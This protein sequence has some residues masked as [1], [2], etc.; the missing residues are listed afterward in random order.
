MPVRFRLWSLCSV[1]DDSEERV[2]S[3]IILIFFVG[4]HVPLLFQYLSRRT[5]PNIWYVPFRRM[6]EI[7]CV[8]FVLLRT[9]CYPRRH[10]KVPLI[11][12]FSSRYFKLSCPLC[13]VEYGDGRRHYQ[14][15]NNHSSLSW[16]GLLLQFSCSKSPMGISSLLGHGMYFSRNSYYLHG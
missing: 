9:L 11:R 15:W 4:L 2:Y 16:S 13:V 3:V 6:C 14:S 10:Q 12:Q 8:C 5:L 1:C 7:T